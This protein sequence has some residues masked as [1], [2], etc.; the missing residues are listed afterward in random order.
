[1]DLHQARWCLLSQEPSTA[2]IT[3]RPME[4]EVWAHDRWTLGRLKIRLRGKE[5]TGLGPCSLG[6]QTG[7]T[8]DGQG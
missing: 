6:Q 3:P 7:K 8:S 2:G 4:W 5:D 1:M